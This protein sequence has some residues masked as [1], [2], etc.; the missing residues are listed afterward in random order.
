MK[1]VAVVTGATSG[2]GKAVTELLLRQNVHVI[3]LGRNQNRIQSVIDEFSS[4]KTEGSLDFVLGDLSDNAQTKKAA[5]DLIKVLKEKYDGQLDLLYNIA[6]IVSTGYHE[7]VDQIERT[8]AVN[9]LA[10]FHLTSLLYPFLEK[11]KHSRVLVVSSYSHYWARVKWNNIQSKRFYNVLKSYSRSKLYNVLFV[12]AFAK[13][14][15]KVSIYA[16]DPGLVNTEI[17]AKKTSG[18]V[19]WVWNQRR[20]KGTDAYYPARFMVD[21]GLS[22]DYLNLSGAYIKEGKSIPPSKRSENLMD[23]EKMWTYS[24]KLLNIKF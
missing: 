11:T 17:G 18:L 5:E 9:H 22:D 1:K 7:N 8:F 13:R 23:Q 15:D 3:A 12:K 2:I 20:K 14:F 6:G 16:I 10:V 21:V 4:I 19:N 24:E